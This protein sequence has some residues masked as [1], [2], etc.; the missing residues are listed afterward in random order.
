MVPRG[1]EWSRLSENCYL[2]FG[3]RGI[4]IYGVGDRAR[5]ALQIFFQFRSIE[6]GQLNVCFALLFV[7]PRV[8]QFVAPHDVSNAPFTSGRF[9]TLRQFDHE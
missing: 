4:C 6:Y 3:H 5:R 8:W 9:S 1:G 7:R 2:T